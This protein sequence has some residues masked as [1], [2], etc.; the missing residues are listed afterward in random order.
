[1]LYPLAIWLGQDYIEPR[2]LSLLLLVTILARLPMMKT[3]RIATGLAAAAAVLMV[4]AAWKNVLLPLKLYPF[5][6]NMGMLL[7]FGLSL[8]YPPS[9]IERFARIKEPEL[10]DAGVRY[11]KR[12]TQIW[13][14]FFALNGAMAFFTSFFFSDAVWSLYN[15]FIA[16]L[17]MGFLFAVEYFFRLRFKR[18]RH[19]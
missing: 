9:I 3:H 1:M 14:A 10:S 18:T 2:W 19:G 7:L 4:L 16:Y 5:L 13:C 11:T 6:V 12:V 15:G 17:L 8:V